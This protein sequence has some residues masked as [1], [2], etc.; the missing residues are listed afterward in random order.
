VLRRLATDSTEQR[1]ATVKLGTAPSV[2]ELALEFDDVHRS[3]PLLLERGVLT[4]PEKKALD[5]LDSYLRSLSGSANAGLWTLD[6][7]DRPE[8][9]HVRRLAGAALV[10]LHSERGTRIAAH[11]LDRDDL[12]LIRACLDAAVVGAF[13]EEWEFHTLFGL[14]REEVARVRDGWPDNASEPNAELA[15]RNSIA[16]L[17]GYPH[18]QDAELRRLLCVDRTSLRE[19]LDRIDDAAR[20]WRAP[21]DT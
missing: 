14:E 6:A 18:G 5:A 9:E 15:V 19:L 2:D 1:L 17:L 4:E 11:W 16:N 12:A 8:W 7:L 13:F 3:A 20:F 21:S 10:A